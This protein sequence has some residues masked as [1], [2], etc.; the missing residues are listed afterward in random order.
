MAAARRGAAFRAPAG[1]PRPRLVRLARGRI[2]AHADGQARGGCA[3]EPA[4]LL[5]GDPVRAL[6]G[7]R[8][9]HRGRD[10]R[11]PS[12]GDGGRPARIQLDVLRIPVPLR[13]GRGALCLRVPAGLEGPRAPRRAVTSRAVGAWVALALA[14]YAALA[15]LSQRHK[16]AVFDEIIHLPP[17]YAIV[18]LG[19]HRMNPLHPPLARVISAWPL[20]FM[21]VHVDADDLAWRTARP[22]E[23]GKRFLYRW[24]DGDRL[25]FWGRLPIVALAMILAVAVFLWA[26]RLWGLPAGFLA[27]LLCVL[28]P[29]VL[30]HGHLATDDLPVV[31]FVFLSVIAFERLV[32]R[33][34]LARVALVALAV[35][36]AFATKFSAFALPPILIALSLVMALRREALSVAIGRPREVQGRGTKLLVLVGVVVVIGA[37]A[38]VVVWAAYGFHSALTP[39]PA[40]DTFMHAH[41]APPAVREP[42]VVPARGVL[43]HRLVVLLPRRHRAEG[44][45]RPPAPGPGGGSARLDAS[46]AGP[47]AMVRVASSGP[48]PR[49]HH[50]A[51]HQHRTPARPRHLSFS[52]RGRLARG[53]PGLVGAGARGHVG[54]GRGGRPR[55][56]VRGQRPP[57]APG[58]PRVLQRGGG[59][60][61]AGLA[62]ARGLERRLGAGPARPQALHGRERDPA[63]DAVLLRH[64]RSRLLRDRG[65]PPAQLPA[66]AAVHDRARRPSG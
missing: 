23:W 26:R 30:A 16:S 33:V 18:K 25:L 56:L 50:D 41:D 52:I 57:R 21:D 27:L 13:A 48:L 35:G 45:A 20:L 11:E 1:E 29:D 38:L 44:A 31:L 55:P 42:S 10:G 34:T 65:R 9:L 6:P 64:R 43:R 5:L 63:G 24:N 61:R 49:P 58:L 37:L 15:T 46:G 12:G 36:A 14:V 60:P 59:R 2:R 22:W 62:L 19:D 40:V 54:A 32:E 7:H 28:N 8:R 39:D 51:E 47:G 53:Q 17:G 66:S 3:L 4:Q